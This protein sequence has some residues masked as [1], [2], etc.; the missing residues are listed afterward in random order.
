MAVINP[1]MTQLQSD[2]L[3][4]CC[5]RPFSILGIQPDPKR[6]TSY[7]RVWLPIADELLLADEASGLPLAD[8]KPVDGAAGLFE[9]ELASKEIPAVY[10]VQGTSQNGSE[11]SLIDSYQFGRYCLQESGVDVYR[12][13]RH[14]GAHPATHQWTDQC[15]NE[16]EI[17][18]VL[19][20]VYAPHARSVSL[21]GSFNQWDGRLLPMASA[22]DGVWRLFVPGVVTGDQYKYEIRGQ[23]GELL[24]NKADPFGFFAEQAPGN[25]SIVYDHGNYHWNDH[26]WKR[27]Q[28][29]D[30]AVSIY[31]VHAGSWKKKPGDESKEC[32]C[33][34][35]LADQLIPYVKE[36]GFTHIEF[37]PLSEHPFTGSWGYQPVGLFAPTSRFGN[38][39]DF[40]AFVDCCHQQGIS[41]I[42]DWVPAHFPED[43]HGLGRFDGTALY[44][45][46]DPRRGWH[47]DWKTLI[48]DY[49]KPFV[50]HFL[51]SNALYWLEEFHIDGL[52]VDAVA[53]MLYLDYSRQHG[54]WEPN[55]HG[56]NEHLE[57]ISF[58]KELNETV[59]SAVPGCMMIAEES[60]SWPGVSR[61]TYGNGL[62][63]SHKWNMGWMHDSLE[64]MKQDPVHRQYHHG[65]MTFSMAYHYSENFILPLS[66]DEVVH[67]KG[68]L[69]TRMPGDEWQ[70]YANLRAYYGFMFA[71][72]G[73]KMLFMG[74][75]LGTNREWNHDT[76]LDWPLLE[77]PFPAGVSKLI[78]DLNRVYRQYAGFWAGDYNPSGFQWLIGDD[79]ERSVFAFCRQG[80]NEAHNECVILAISN[81]TPMIRYDYR[82]GVPK[83]GR[84]LEVLNT[85]SE[86]Y[87]GSN[88]GNAGEI[89]AML[90]A[91]H[92]QLHGQPASLTLTLPP[93]A[94][95][96]LVFCNS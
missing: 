17:T 89:T 74:A 52:R 91:S 55:V 30:T 37:L 26:E 12:L 71:H 83:A 20:R 2:L 65:Q 11:I 70:Q 15:G 85:D 82:V 10:R 22:D 50:R 31:E 67:G 47:P 25:A 68:T 1:E 16:A 42:L 6:D 86:L 59:F 80:I 23:S 64:Y 24:P 18:G 8:L 45:Y 84:W 21:I 7:I 19:F 63:F 69:L 36:M 87:G 14:M 54:E 96:Y 9:C 43:P 27:D 51:V 44:E 5:A 13:H 75:E 53:S 33:Y 38:P 60:T 93:L 34:S 39:D 95:L 40:K 78:Q 76:E 66:H 57:A 48:Y 94:T 77:Q 61:P 49:G 32:L 41:V 90:E 56:G 72:P 29:R 28:G 35:E 46:E 73:K 92:N 4:S 79:A 88:V 58:L 81:M 62:G 3:R